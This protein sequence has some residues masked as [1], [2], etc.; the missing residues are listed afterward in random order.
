[1]IHTLSKD[2]GASFQANL[3]Y[4]KNK[5]VYKDEPD[6]PTIWK[7]E[8]GKPYSR[9]LSDPIYYPSAYQYIN[10]SFRPLVPD[11]RYLPVGG[12]L[13]YRQR[14][15]RS[16]VLPNR[17]QGVSGRFTYDYGQRYLAEINYPKSCS[18]LMTVFNVFAF[19][20]L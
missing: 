13:M 11:H 7:S 12:M 20:S 3:T 10:N 17:N 8:T 9:F 16:D 18:T 6:Y 4:N 19:C 14:E 5:L 1:M 15:Y 2:L